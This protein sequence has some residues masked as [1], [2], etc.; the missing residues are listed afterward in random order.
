MGGDLRGRRQQ[1]RGASACHVTTPS[2]SIVVP[3]F[4][5]AATLP[6][7][8]DALSR[9]RVE[10]PVEV[11]AIDSGSTDGS[12]DLLRAAGVKLIT[13]PPR[14]FNHGLTRNLGIEAAAGELIVLI[15][16]DAVPVSDTWLA[17]LTRPLAQDAGL[18]GTF[19]R[20]LPR[21]D[22]GA[23]TRH[24]LA[25]WFAASDVA[26]T[27]AATAAE[28]EALPP[29][30]RLDRCTFD[31]VCSCVKRSVW[32]HHPFRKTPIGEDVE[33]A[34]EV[35]VSGHRIAYVPDAVVFHSHERSA[36]YEFER[37]RVLH[38]RLY[39][40]FGVRTIPTALHLARAIASCVVAHAQCELSMR[41][42]ALAFAW[43]LGQYA[44]ARAAVRD[45]RL[46]PSRAV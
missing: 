43:P 31:N 7:L 14:A 20:Q 30:A 18:A 9:Q 15:V 8:L 39:E 34:R 29:L 38:R 23:L 45:S 16:Q 46:R 42:M 32:Q 5:G 25:R 2:I 28:L 27:V 44:G 22:A 40:L 17:T 12:V 3:T 36:A 13:I 19:G 24:Y 11:V 4:N 26:R 10:R 1:A 33:W 6:A 35:L 37:T 21:P 41:A